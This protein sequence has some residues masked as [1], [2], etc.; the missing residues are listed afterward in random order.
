MQALRD[1][2]EHA[3][4]D[5]GAIGARLEYESVD[6][7]VAVLEALGALGAHAEERARANA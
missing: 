1:L 7:R 3:K 5:F 4:E 2:G 6:V